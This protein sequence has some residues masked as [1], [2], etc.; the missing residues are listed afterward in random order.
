MANSKAMV[1]SFDKPRAYLCQYCDRECDK[2]CP[3]R[4]HTRSIKRA[5]FT[6][7]QCGQCLNACDKVQQKNSGTLNGHKVNKRVINWVTGEKAKAVDRNVPA[8]ELKKIN[9]QK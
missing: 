1:V 4:L 7:T 8:F 2:A 3:M 6:C 5:K 9:K